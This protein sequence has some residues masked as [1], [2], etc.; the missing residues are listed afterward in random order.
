MRNYLAGIDHFYIYGDDSSDEEQTRTNS[1]ITN[2]SPLVTYLPRGRLLPVDAENST[3]YV[4]MRVYRHCLST[5]GPTTHWMAFID[6]DEMFETDI[7]AQLQPIRRLRGAHAFMHDVLEAHERFPVLCIRWRTVL[8]NGRIQPAKREMP[9]LDAHAVSCE[10]VINNTIKLSL[11][12][13]ILQPRFVNLTAT[14]RLD[15]ALH[16]GFKMNRPLHKFNCLWGTGAT[17][18]PPIYLAHYW[19]RSLYEYVQK[20]ARGRP[21]KGVPARALLDLVKREQ[22][23]TPD[24]N[25]VI[26]SS[27]KAVVRGFGD[28]FAKVGNTPIDTDAARD[29]L[30]SLEKT[31][32]AELCV[33][34]IRTLVGKMVD[35]YTLSTPLYCEQNGASKACGKSEGGDKFGW[36]FVWSEFL[37]I[38]D[39]DID[40]DRLFIRV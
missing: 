27:R 2:F 13:T 26:D 39:G 18:T 8:T 36:P 7:L 37:Q 4:Q 9:L 5:F 1:V 32:D 19:S 40:E 12:K 11:R 3:N 17:L 22:V 14:P 25:T 35:G 16:K 15:V 20:I 28:V 24:P 33:Q 31:D 10:P 6:A 30:E 29:Y 23:C 34:R 38:C 21:R